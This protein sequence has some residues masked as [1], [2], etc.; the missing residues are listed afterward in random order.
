MRGLPALVNNMRKTIIKILT[1]ATLMAT[2]F[3][4]T[5]ALAEESSAGATG[6][7]NTG[8]AATASTTRYKT[9]SELR[10]QLEQKRSEVKANLEAKK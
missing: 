4:V 10:E 3:V 2:L 6:S 8:T 1:G 9:P 5:P 7:T